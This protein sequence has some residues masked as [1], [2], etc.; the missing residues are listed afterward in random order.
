MDVK[1]N[2]SK[3]IQ[4]VCL[5]IKDHER[6]PDVFLALNAH[7]TPWNIQAEC[8]FSAHLLGMC[9]NWR[10]KS[11]RFLLSA[12]DWRR[13]SDTRPIPHFP[14]RMCKIIS[15]FVYRD[16]IYEHKTKWTIKV[17]F[18]LKA[19]KAGQ[20]YTRMS[21]AGSQTK[22]KTAFVVMRV[23]NR[24]LYMIIHLLRYG[25]KHDERNGHPNKYRN[26]KWRS[27]RYRKE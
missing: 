13:L 3:I 9:N 21:F 25:W 4:A 10:N 22:I 6:A 23:Y 7:F 19:I 5:R 24:R 2:A 27:L 18:I 8:I 1:R 15:T 26:H 11:A 16:P 20:L 17:F 14:H 12:L